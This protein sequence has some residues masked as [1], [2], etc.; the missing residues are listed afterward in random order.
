MATGIAPEKWARHFDTVSVCFSK[1]LGASVGSA[2]A[3]PRDLIKRALWHRKLFGG[4]MRQAGIIAAGALYALDHQIDRLVEDHENA[5]ILA[6]AIRNTYGLELRPPEV[7]TNLVIFKV[8]PRLGTA[9]EFTARLKERGLLVGA[10]GASDDPRC[11]ASRRQPR[12]L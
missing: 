6:E 3:G 7:D 10:F 1:G 12:R 9:N 11:H 2:L 8:D 5:Q 4:A